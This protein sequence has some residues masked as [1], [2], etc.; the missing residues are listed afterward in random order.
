[1]AFLPLGIPVRGGLSTAKRVIQF[2]F[3]VLIK[4]KASTR[5]RRAGYFLLLVQEKVTKENTPQH[6]TSAARKCPALLGID[7]VG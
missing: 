1:M 4:N 2:D 6:R 3:F 7:G 5:L